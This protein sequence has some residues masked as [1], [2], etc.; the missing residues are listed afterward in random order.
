MDWFAALR[1]RLAAILEPN[2]KGS[3]TA[4]EESDPSSDVQRLVDRA[5]ALARDDRVDVEALAELANLSRGQRWIVFEAEAACLARDDDFQLRG[6]AAY[7][8]E[9]SLY[10]DASVVTRPPTIAERVKVAF[11]DKST[12]SYADQY[13]EAL[14]S[15]IRESSNII[16][17]MALLAL[18]GLGAFELLSLDPPTPEFPAAWSACGA[19]LNR[20]VG[21]LEHDPEVWRPV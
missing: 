21:V 12:A 20:V 8:L 14:Q 2:S 16:R 1:S 18:L 10:E 11:A 5:L 6:R 4:V 17:R 7:L 3:A 13:L 9:R 19:G 15:R